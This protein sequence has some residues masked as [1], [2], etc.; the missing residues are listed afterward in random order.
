M[1]RQPEDEPPAQPQPSP[2]PATPALHPEGTDEA[3]TATPAD[4]YVPVTRARDG[5]DWRIGTDVDVAWIAGGTSPGL[6]ISAAV[7]PVFDAYATFVEPDSDERW[8]KRDRAV[9]ALLTE[10]SA[11]QAWWLGYLD[12]GV[13]DIIFADAPMVTLYSGWRYVLVE[14]GWEQATSWRANERGMHGVLPE[15]MFPADRSW[16]LST[17]WDHDWTCIGGSAEF[18]DSFVRHPDLQARP[19]EL[20]QD[21]TP[22]GHQAI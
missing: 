3:I 8:E 18:V 6:T 10:Y 15:V 17:L 4:P 7:P 11:G 1:I 14:A 13:D 5:R 19:V 2:W 21:A 12:T 9:I 16:L 22:P 20:G